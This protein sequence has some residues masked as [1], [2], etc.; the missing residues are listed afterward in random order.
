M[1]RIIKCKLCGSNWIIAYQK[2]KPANKPHEYYIHC[3][4]CNKTGWIGEE[5]NERVK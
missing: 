5:S 2:R 3:Y 1:K 4:R